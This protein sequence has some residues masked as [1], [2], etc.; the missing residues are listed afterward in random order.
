M[1]VKVEGRLRGP[2]SPSPPSCLSFKPKTQSTQRI[3]KDRE[4]SPTKAQS[5]CFEQYSTRAFHSRLCV[6]FV[7]FVSLR[8]SIKPK[9]QS[10]QRIRKDREAS[11]TKAQRRRE[12]TRAQSSPES[13]SESSFPRE[14]LRLFEEFPRLAYN[15]CTLKK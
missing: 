9:T 4:A 13:P 11:P 8:L 1:P 5:P 10:T 7:Y 14:P 3:R 15:T 2:R 12:L 6:L